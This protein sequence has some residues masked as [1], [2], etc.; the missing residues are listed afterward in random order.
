VSV[1]GRQQPIPGEIQA[2]LQV[3][4]ARMAS[5]FVVFTRA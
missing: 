1:P 4:Q 5:M 3:G 2:M